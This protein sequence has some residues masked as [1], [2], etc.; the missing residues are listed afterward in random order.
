MKTRFYISFSSIAVVL[1]VLTYLFLAELE[2]HSG[3]LLKGLSL[4]AI[5]VAV[6][7][8]FRVFTRFMKMP[9]GKEQQ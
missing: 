8:L 9:S 2:Q 1:I 6:V 5:S 7:L 4:A 3:W